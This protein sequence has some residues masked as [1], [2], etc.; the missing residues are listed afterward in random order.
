MVHPSRSRAARKWALPE[1]ALAKRV[2][3]A[4]GTLIAQ[5]L[6]WM[7]SLRLRDVSIVDIYWGFGF[8]QIAIIAASLAG[9]RACRISADSARVS[10]R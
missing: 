5:L 7:L 1:A 8:A 4:L 10:R 6:L 2:A 3:T 9:G